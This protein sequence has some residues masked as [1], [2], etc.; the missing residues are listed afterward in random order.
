MK[1]I[2]LGAKA[3]WGTEHEDQVLVLS[4]PGGSRTRMEIRIK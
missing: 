1:A 4:P 2:I 3:P